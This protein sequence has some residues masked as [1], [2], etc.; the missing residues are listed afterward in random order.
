MWESSPVGPADGS[1]ATMRSCPARC[2]GVIAA[3]VSAAQLGLFF[4]PDVEDGAV[5]V[6]ESLVLGNEA[7]LVAVGA[8]SSPHAASMVAA[9]APA[10]IGAANR[11]VLVVSTGRDA[12][13]PNLAV[14]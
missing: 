9:S 1:S 14:A 5:E 13:V 7:S 2:V 12:T 8:D 4:V 10:R 3:A 11:R 6:V